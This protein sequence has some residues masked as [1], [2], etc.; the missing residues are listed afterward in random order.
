MAARHRRTWCVV[1]QGDVHGASGY[2][3]SIVRLE[4]EHAA[5][6]AFTVL[7]YA[8]GGLGPILGFDPRYRVLVGRVG[9]EELIGVREARTLKRATQRL[10]EVEQILATSSEDEARAALGLDI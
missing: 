2:Q 6:L 1:R 3:A 8:T 10:A 9:N 7:D 4:S 5:G